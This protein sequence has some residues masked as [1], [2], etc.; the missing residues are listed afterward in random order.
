VTESTEAALDHWL[1]QQRQTNVV[2][3]NSGSEMRIEDG[4]KYEEQSTS[5]TERR[6]IRWSVQLE[7]S[8][9]EWCMVD[10]R[11]AR[12]G[13]TERA[14][15]APSIST[16]H[17]HHSV[18]ATILKLIPQRFALPYVPNKPLSIFTQ[19]FARVWPF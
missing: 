12:G 9:D 11:Q 10:D 17:P 2:R 3:I 4:R 19:N 6:S 8:T 15:T 14:A 18:S 7:R 5:E 1:Q 13:G 16:P